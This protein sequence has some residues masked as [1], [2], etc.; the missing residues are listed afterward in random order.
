MMIESKRRSLI[1]SFSWRL[2]ATLTTTIISFLITGEITMALKIG[3]IEMI[4][5]M[6]L[7]YFHERLWSKIHYGLVE[8]QPNYHI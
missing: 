4:A 7:Y 3:G 1:K 8:R 5:K 6:G 2:W